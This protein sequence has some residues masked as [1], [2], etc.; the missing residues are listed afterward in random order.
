MIQFKTNGTNENCVVRINGTVVTNNAYVYDYGDYG[1]AW[2]EIEAVE[3]YAFDENTS[4]NLNLSP[5][6]EYGNPLTDEYGNP[7]GVY[8]TVTTGG[9][10]ASNWNSTFSKFTYT[11]DQYFAGSVEVKNAVAVEAVEEEPVYEVNPTFSNV[12][13]VDVFVNDIPVIDGVTFD[14]GALEFVLRIACHDGYAFNET[15]PFDITL[16][17]APT[18]VDTTN[19]ELKDNWNEDYTVFETEFQWFEPSPLMFL[20]LANVSPAEIT[21]EEPEFS[22]ANVFALVYSPTPEQL[23]SIS[24]DRY[25]TLG[26]SGDMEALDI[27]RYF[28][29]LYSTPFDLSEH[30]LPTAT[31]V[32]VGGKVLDT[33]ACLMES[34]VVE[35]DLGSIEVSAKYNNAYDYVNTSCY[36]HLPFMK[37][38]EL[39]VAR[40]IDRVVHA[41]YTLDL[42]SG[43]ATLNTYSD[44]LIMNSIEVN[45]GLKIPFYQQL[46]DG[47]TQVTS[48]ML[49]NT[50][51]TPYIEVVRNI[52]YD[53]S[54][55]YGYGRL[56]RGVVGDYTGF[57]V[58]S[59]VQLTTNAT[60]VE[61]REIERILANGVYL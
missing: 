51:T 58:V 1:A 7:L 28:N 27:G 12:E 9:S 59:S 36:L 29:N 45:L 48:N 53:D 14:R 21:G 44:G 33:K 46:T 60:R 4:F 11:L 22:P 15:T 47:M 3:G 49:L 8:H 57:V 18:L 6:D 50:V 24:N 42:Y 54:G 10:W 30:R 16:D 23:E 13:N 34:A 19:P 37:S 17:G 25:I 56:E 2:V 55:V 20:D 40:V 39:D 43:K 31:N 26:S 32:L 5:T 41:K 35:I 61:Q 52:P 38:V